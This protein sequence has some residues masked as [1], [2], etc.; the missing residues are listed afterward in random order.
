MDSAETSY[1]QKAEDDVQKEDESIM[2]ENKEKEMKLKEIKN[3]LNS[4]LQEIF[5]K[6]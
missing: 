4:G 6:S 2:N 5:N 1:F 3:M